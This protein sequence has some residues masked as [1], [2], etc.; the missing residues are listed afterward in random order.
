M[1]CED[2]RQC[3]A[4]SVIRLAFVSVDKESQ[5]VESLHNPKCLAACDIMF[6]HL[7][8]ERVDLSHS[9]QLEI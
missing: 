5:V 6:A 9:Q 1:F 3:L 8:L 4:R 7:I 2:V